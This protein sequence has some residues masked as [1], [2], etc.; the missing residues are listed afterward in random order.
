MAK[1]VR[2]FKRLLGA[3]TEPGKYATPSATDYR[4]PS[5][6]S[7]TTPDREYKASLI[8]KSENLAA[9]NYFQRHKMNTMEH[10][11][12]AEEVFKLKSGG[13]AIGHDEAERLWLE[14]KHE[15]T[16]FRRSKNYMGY[17]MMNMN[18]TDAY[19]DMVPTAETGGI[20]RLPNYDHLAISVDEILAS[21]A[22]DPDEEDEEKI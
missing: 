8:P 18:F 17:D 5:P 20:P 15:V 12:P 21:C 7:A 1:V 19:S 6:G 13:A 11:L 2:A 9:Q 10:L 22:P 14:R 3:F 16:A 4:Y